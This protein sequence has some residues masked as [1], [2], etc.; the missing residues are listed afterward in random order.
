MS[1]LAKHPLLVFGLGFAAGFYAHQ[2]RKEIIQAAVQGAE[3]AKKTFLRQ[4]DHLEEVVTAKH[5]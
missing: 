2:Y 5:H 4:A 3:E 1:I